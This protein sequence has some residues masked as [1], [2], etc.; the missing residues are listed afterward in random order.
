[1]TNI[2]F[3]RVFELCPHGLVI[4]DK[5]LIIVHANDIVLNR[6]SINEIEGKKL[7]DIFNE[8]THVELEKSKSCDHNSNILCID[9]EYS[10]RD[11]Y[12]WFELSM[13]KVC[14]T[15]LI[16][17]DMIVWSVSDI[18]IRKIRE[19]ELEEL[20]YID[21]LTACYTRRHF[22]YLADLQL[23]NYHLYDKEFCLILFDVDDF[24]SINDN[25]GHII[26][27]VV[28]TNIAS[29]A[30]CMLRDDDMIGRVGGEEFAIIISNDD[31]QYNISFAENLRLEIERKLIDPEVTISIG[32]TFVN[33]YDKNIKDMVRRSDE[34][35]Y[36]A[37]KKGKNNVVYRF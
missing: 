5:N 6:L 18:S 21:G 12:S 2:D 3:K 17:N 24:K 23:E 29:V 25:Y 1:M 14:Y 7:T 32:L 36:I 35:L 4:T 26:G 15:D 31:Q 20:A 11:T 28:L 34:A 8:V 10:Y 13:N 9:C 19:K 37:K 16:N 30:K 22:F 27:D 33:E